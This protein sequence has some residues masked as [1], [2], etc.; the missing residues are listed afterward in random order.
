MKDFQ[1][2]VMLGGEIVQIGCIYFV[3]DLGLQVQCGG[4][5]WVECIVVYVMNGMFSV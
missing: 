4:F 3:V 5:G 1:W 2:Q